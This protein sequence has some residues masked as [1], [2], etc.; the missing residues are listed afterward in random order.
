MVRALPSIDS[1][2]KRAFKSLN[3]NYRLLILALM[4][5]GEKMLLEACVNTGNAQTSQGLGALVRN[6]QH[7]GLRFLVAFSGVFAVL[8]Y[9]RLRN[10]LT[11][12]DDTI[13]TTPIRLSWLWAHILLIALLMALSHLLYVNGNSSLAF[14]IEASAW[15]LLGLFAALTA[16]LCMAPWSVWSH[17]LRAPGTVWLYAGIA[18]LLGTGAWSASQS[19]WVPVT[20]ITFDL[21]RLVLLPVLPTLKSDDA[22]R[23][24]STDHFAVEITNYC[25]GL[26]G[27]GLMLVF[28]AVWL[29]YFRREYIFPRALLLIPAGLIAMFCLNVLRIAALLLIGNAGYP[30]VAAFGFH[31]QAGWIAFTLVA[32]GVVSLSRRSA[33]LNR[34]AAP[35]GQSHR[36][37]NKTAPY[38][39]P[40]LA[41]LGAGAI[42]RAFSGTFETFYALRW[43]AGAAA[44]IC[45]RKAL[46]TLHWRFS[47]RGPA[48]GALV[49]VLWIVAADLLIPDAT[50]PSELVRLGSGEQT[51]W[52]ATRLTGSIF[53]VPLAE[54][55]GYRGYLMRRLVSVDFDQVP[56][57][58]VTPVAIGIT[59]IAF[60]VVHG[61]LWGPGILA[62]M[63][64]GGLAAHRNSLGEAVAA[65]ATTNAL[66]GAAV[67]LFGDWRLW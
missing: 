36:S 13:R 67:L 65:H 20:G 28:I 62:G 23:I 66:L 60:G 15:I 22:T 7:W 55:L 58:A 37:E 32:C 21:V 5:L 52:I 34:D 47:W 53:L 42:S 9:V 10:Q 31:S 39:I 51:L 38:L 25:S 26:E 45:Y 44:L 57:R 30:D 6:A 49:F 64:Y 56:Y 12:L 43:A 46:L 41:I 61:A 4:I 19:L 29:H 18:A 59:A 27:M 54:E 1:P 50:M 11:W 48:V 3:F 14:G 33:W 63:A 16:A 35:A 17:V 8:T 2:G 40:L 24:V